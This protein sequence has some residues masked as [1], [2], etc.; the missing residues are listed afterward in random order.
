MRYIRLSDGDVTKELVVQGII[1][2]GVFLACSLFIDYFGLCRSGRMQLIDAFVTI[3]ISIAVFAML[4]RKFQYI[5]PATLEE[6][7]NYVAKID[8]KAGITYFTEK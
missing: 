2:I 3:V 4:N 1:Q 7:V 8:C 6:S 5:S